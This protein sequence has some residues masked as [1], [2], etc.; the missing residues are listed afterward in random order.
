MRSGRTRSVYLLAGEYSCPRDVTPAKV[1][2]EPRARGGA[3]PPPLEHLM[4]LACERCLDSLGG[5]DAAPAV[6]HLL[7]ITFPGRDATF[8]SEVLNRFLDLKKKLG[9]GERC[10]TRFELGSSDAGAVLFSSALQQLRGA[11]GPATALVVAGQSF[12]PNANV[13]DTVARVV[14]AEE[15]TVGLNMVAVGD[16]LVDAVFHRW[17]AEVGGVARPGVEGEFRAFL[18]AWMDS[19]L[20][21]ADEYPAA[22]RSHR[23]AAAQPPRWNRPYGRWMGYQHM[24]WAS[25]GA[26]A[27]ALTT[28]RALV[29]RWIERERAQGRRPRLVR[30]LGVGEGD[31]R[32]A[33]TRRAE[34][35]VYFKAMR[36]ALSELRRTTGTNLDFLRASSFAVLHD[37][38]PSIEMAFLLSLGFSPFDA[39]QRALTWW[40]NPYGGLLAFGHALAASGLVQIARAF[41]AFTRPENY[42]PGPGVLHP[43]LTT[44]RDVTHCLTTSVGGPM[45]HV[46][47]T[48]LQA[49]PLDEAWE[50]SADRASV[51]PGAR[52]R[53]LNDE[54]P[55]EQPFAPERRHRLESFDS[56]SFEHKT[57]WVS[58]VARRYVDALGADL[59]VLEARSSF[60]LA[61]VPD[62]LL[63]LPAVFLA[64][65]R[66]EPVCYGTWRAT[67]PDAL[68]ERLRALLST[69][70]EDAE[71]RGPIDLACEAVDSHA[72]ALFSAWKL[73]HPDAAEDRVVRQD[74]RDALY[75][76]LRL[77]VGLVSARGGSAL[78]A[79]PDPETSHRLCLLSAAVMSPDAP[80]VGTLVRLDEHPRIAVVVAVE[81]A[82]PGLVPPWYR[83]PAHAYGPVR[84]PTVTQVDA[85]FNLTR[86]L[87]SGPMSREI[88]QGLRDVAAEAI[89]DLLAAPELAAHPGLVRLMHEL[90]LDPDEDRSRLLAALEVWLGADVARRA[91]DGETFACCAF[92]LALEDRH[93][94][95]S[96]KLE[97]VARAI[98]R[99]EGWFGGSDVIHERVGEVFAI[100]VSD[101]RT[102][103]VDARSWTATARFAR[104]VYQACL[105]E[106]VRVRAATC[107]DRGQRFREVDAHHGV[108]G[109]V[110]QA[111]DRC[112][113][114]GDPREDGVALVMRAT[115]AARMAGEAESFE[116]VWS[117]VGGERLE[118]AARGD[119]STSAGERAWRF[120][121]ERRRRHDAA[122]PGPVTTTAE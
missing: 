78:G 69:R 70:D 9:L 63:P 95:L 13:I 109:A 2:T 31:A 116:R 74:L 83:D 14:E 113:R 73:D 45:T 115:V 35:F 68:V 79:I 5:G 37:A 40:P 50:Q 96:R 65:W 20:R 71:G 29:E 15:R 64:G 3:A 24:A 100:T 60:T 43:D 12:P 118:V 1:F 26:C 59:A 120:C 52:R 106:G 27:V 82:L 98:R 90:V 89:D 4:R 17:A 57:R 41:H 107:I 10:Q 84:S 87:R 85:L 62:G 47:A 34:P 86:A 48:L 105:R 30:V 22:Q 117:L 44:T 76:A 114:E 101:P 23:D 39:A 122:V 112:L 75:H 67:V 11:D 103:A 93:D 110:Q 18:D 49:F 77:P 16:L 58:D 97:T 121:Y 32:G 19:K 7:G 51:P 119:F 6:T 55:S 108:V 81:R 66:A 25:V 72:V 46:V 99:A 92:A 53:W 21:L 80:P 61:R 102:R 36:Q 33:L 38:F 91:D 88:L 42:L 28:D 104:D 8:L 94:D 111:V 56:E 54:A